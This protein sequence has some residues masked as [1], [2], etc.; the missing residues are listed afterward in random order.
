MTEGPKSRLIVCV[1]PGGCGAPAATRF[2]GDGTGGSGKLGSP[3][4][5]QAACVAAASQ[6]AS[7]AVRP[8][9]NGSAA[10]GT[11]SPAAAAPTASESTARRRT[12]RARAIGSAFPRESAR[13][14]PE[15]GAGVPGYLPL[16]ADLLPRGNAG[17]RELLAADSCDVVVD[18]AA[19]AQPAEVVAAAVVERQPVGAVQRH[20]LPDTD[21]D[22]FEV[23]VGRRE[24]S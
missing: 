23:A 7:Y 9:C 5:F 15:A 24:Q 21:V 13:I 16:I 6:R 18:G 1:V 19:A 11:A 12:G 2:V 22:R 17:Q 8:E 14:G 20:R 3:N 4:C 10:L